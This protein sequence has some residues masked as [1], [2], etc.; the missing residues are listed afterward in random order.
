M[1]ASPVAIRSGW[2]AENPQPG[3]THSLPETRASRLVTRHVLDDAEK[4]DPKTRS[5]NDRP[6]S[7]WQSREPSLVAQVFMGVPLNSKSLQHATVRK[8]PDVPPIAR[9]QRQRRHAR[10]S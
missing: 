6:T 7:F 2:Q 9:G 10:D 3:N 1:V 5:R 8:V 4:T